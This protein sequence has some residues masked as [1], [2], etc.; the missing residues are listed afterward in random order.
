[1]GG[2]SSE[3]A[4]A[5]LL[6]CGVAALW[7]PTNSAG[8]NPILG[9]LAWALVVALVGGLLLMGVGYVLKET[10]ENEAPGLASRVEAL[11]AEVA[12][13]RAHAGLPPKAGGPTP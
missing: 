2:Y 8:S 3:G 4:F 12:E 10:A 6:F 11:E 1:V 5:F 13:L 9:V 7:N